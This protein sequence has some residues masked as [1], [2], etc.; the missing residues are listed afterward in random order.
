MMQRLGWLF[1]LRYRLG[2]LTLSA[3]TARLGALTGGARLAIVALR[4]G[5]AA[6]DVDKS[7]DL[8]LVRELAD[9]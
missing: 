6:I 9:R 1:A 2:Q 4:D 7:A 8:D 5:Q 3:A